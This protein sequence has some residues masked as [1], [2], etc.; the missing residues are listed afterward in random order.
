MNVPKYEPRMGA[1]EFNLTLN[2]SMKADDGLS[3]F[4]FIKS[5]TDQ[6]SIIIKSVVNTRKYGVSGKPMIMYF[7]K[8]GNTYGMM[9]TLPED[10][11]ILKILPYGK[12]IVFQVK[13]NQL[14][15]PASEINNQYILFNLL[16]FID[17]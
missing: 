15:S 4:F 3:E 17:K 13:T 2:E 8:T 16:N 1:I 14:S 6:R 10:A 5:P 11:A 9:D 12:Q 7:G